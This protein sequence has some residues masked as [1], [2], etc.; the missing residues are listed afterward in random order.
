MLHY[1]LLD[2]VARVRKRP[3]FPRKTL[4]M[5]FY[6]TVNEEVFSSNKK[7]QM[8][9]IDIRSVNVSTMSTSYPIAFPVGF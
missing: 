2:A 7:R 3:R 6:L 5:G 9:S 4:V 8:E 1:D